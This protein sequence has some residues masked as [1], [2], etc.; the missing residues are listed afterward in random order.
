MAGA[1]GHSSTVRGIRISSKH[2][3]GLGQILVNAKGKTL[4]I[5]EPDKHAKV[6]CLGECA[7]IWPPQFLVGK[8][9]PVAVDKVRQSLLG[10]DPDPSVGE[11]VITYAGWP[12]YTYVD[13]STPASV[14]GQALD[15]NGGLWYVISTSG[16]VIKNKP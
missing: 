6:S 14:G 9:K 10:N 3:P 15:L 5:F 7:E 12:L 8:Q 1:Y 16:K 2:V 13:D 4:Y 11:R